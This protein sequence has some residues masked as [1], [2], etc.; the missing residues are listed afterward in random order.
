MAQLL[1]TFKRVCSEDDCGLEAYYRKQTCYEDWLARQPPVVRC[2]AAER[3]ASLIP[4]AARRATVPAKEWPPG[5]RWCGMCQ[6]FVRLKDCAA[7]ASRCKACSSIANH[8]GRVKATFG[9]DSDSYQWL[10]ALQGGKCAIC[11]ARPKTNRLAVDHDH[12]HCKQGCSKCWRGL[13]CSRCNHELLG[14]AHDSVHILRN[15]V[16]YLESPPARGEWLPP[17]IER[18]EWEKENPGEPLAPF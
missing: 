11:R 14:A 4:E 9:L 16:A 8:A 2:E 15:A 17:Q 1:S 7:G 3:R 12:A 10:L 5:R 18:D 13:L 6:T